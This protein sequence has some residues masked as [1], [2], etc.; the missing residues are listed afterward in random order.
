MKKNKTLN[1]KDEIV[2]VSKNAFKPSKA[3]SRGFSKSEV[4]KKVVGDGDEVVSD[5]ID[6]TE[7]FQESDMESIDSI[8]DETVS[9]DE[10]AIQ[11]FRDVLSMS[12]ED[13][14]NDST[15]RLSPVRLM[16]PPQK[17]W[18]DDASKVKFH[19][20][21][22]VRYKGNVGGL[23]YKVC[24]CAKDE[25]FYI[26]KGSKS[27]DSFNESGDKIVKA[28]KG[29][30]WLDYWSQFPV[31]PAPKPWLKKEEPKS[32]KPKLVKRKK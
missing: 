27:R 4:I 11:I 30:T 2:E 8:S 19:I 29:A 7:P 32:V 12:D 18:E 21:D 25:G 16:P 5:D 1:K 26:L 3:S 15:S 22:L 13:K 17:S 10:E 31:I 9:A 23:T 14:D 28:E 20:G 6:V 24:G